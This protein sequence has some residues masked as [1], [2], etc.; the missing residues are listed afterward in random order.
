MQA[1]GSTPAPVTLKPGV[2]SSYGNG[3]TQLWKHFLGL[4]LIGVIYV[5]LSIVLAVP[6]WI[7]DTGGTA[8]N[9]LSL[10]FSFFGF[11]Y[12]LFIVNPV[13]YGQT[14]AYL[15]AARGDKVEVQDMFAAFQNYW[16]TVAASILVG[17]IVTIGF[18]LII[19]PGIIFACKLAFVP[20]LVVDKKMGVMKAIDTSWHMTNGHAWKVF[21]IGLLGIPVVIAGLICL[22]V[23]VIISIMW[24]QAA[25]ASLYHAVSTEK[26]VAAAPA[27]PPVTPA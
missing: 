1:Q 8:F 12:S 7:A 9:S 13:G 2:F 24:I 4:F 17:I 22:G 20:Y 25:M 5:V 21:L 23:G 27:P 15:K 11:F 18:I 16:N 19:V 26:A 3:W 6:N 14:F 10:L